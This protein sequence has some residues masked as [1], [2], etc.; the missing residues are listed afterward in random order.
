[1]KKINR[2]RFYPVV[3][4]WVIFACLIFFNGSALAGVNS[5]PWVMGYVGDWWLGYNGN[6]AMPIKKINFRGMTVCDYMSILPTTKAP[7]M[8][9]TGNTHPA[10]LLADAAHAAGI[11]CVFTIGAWYTESTF[12]TATNS[13]NLSVF[14]NGL[15]SFTKQCNMDGIDIDW[16]PLVA[17]DTVQWD[18]LITALRKALPSPKYIISVTGGWGSPYEAY[19]NMQDKL[20]QIDIMT[21]DLDTFAPGYNSWYAASVYSNGFVDPFDNKTPVPSCDYLVGLYEQAGVKPLKLGIGCE[22]G[23][24]LWN[25]ITGVDQDISKVSKWTVDIPYDTIMAK[26]YKP[27]LYHWD[28]GAQASYLSFDTTVD[29]L[30]WFLSYDDTTAL[31]AKLYYVYKTGIGGIIIY[32]LGMSYDT[33]TGANPFTNVT[34]HFLDTLSGTGIE[35]TPAVPTELHLSQNYPNPFN[36]TTQVDYSVPKREYVKLE[37]YNVLGQRV[38]TLF[39][40]MRSVGNYTATFN[41]SKLSSGVYF[42]RLTAGAGTVTK[43]LV[44]LK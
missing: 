22:P 7:F 3:S 23:G 8:D 31:A 29:N 9:T 42:Y 11:K 30:D 26:Y 37:V 14:V 40:G 27:S 1:M 13:S 21:Y 19:A 17:A 25:G 35:K 2:Y 16:E 12:M 44:L 24:C 32:E 39:S 43:R 33:H 10:S 41:G 18:A 15:V 38:A 5:K 34:Q 36:P 28:A 20:D 4:L 6:G